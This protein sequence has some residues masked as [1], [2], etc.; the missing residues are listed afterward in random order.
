MLCFVF[1]TAASTQHNCIFFPT[2]NIGLN[3]IHPCERVGRKY[4]QEI[5]RRMMRMEWSYICFLVTTGQSPVFLLPSSGRR[6][7]GGWRLSRTV[8]DLL[9]SSQYIRWDWRLRRAHAPGRITEINYWLEVFTCL[10]APNC[11]AILPLKLPD[12]VVTLSGVYS[13]R[14]GIFSI[15]KL[16]FDWCFIN[17]MGFTIINPVFTTFLRQFGFYIFLSALKYDDQMKSLLRNMSFNWKDK[18]TWNLFYFFISIKSDKN[19][20]IFCNDHLPLS[21]SILIWWKVCHGLQQNPLKYN[22]TFAPIKC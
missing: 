6:Q 13:V 18:Q 21:Y 5:L 12:W 16:V 7:A 14:T 2:Y 3:V 8:W 19:L 10:I 15:R 9:S 17:F 4:F 1:L 20:D 11:W 22:M